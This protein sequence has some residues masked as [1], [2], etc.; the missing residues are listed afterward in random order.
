MIEGK[1]DLVFGQGHAD[2]VGGVIGQLAQFIDRF[3]RH[4]HAGQGF[5]TLRQRHLEP[6]QAMTVGRDRAQD[7]HRAVGRP[8]QV[9][10]VQ[11]I[12]RFLGAH[13]EF[14]TVNQ[15]AEFVR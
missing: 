14:G 10:A 12:P 7:F 13:R 5:R 8:V 4:N 6:G 2:G 15:R 11:V 3:A 1:A 9:N